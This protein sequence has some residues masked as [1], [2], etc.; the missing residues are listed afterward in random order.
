[1]KSRNPC[2]CR[3][4]WVKHP[5]GFKWTTN[6]GDGLHDIG[7]IEGADMQFEDYQ[8]Q[9]NQTAVYPPENGLAYTALGLAGE[10]GEIANKVKKVLRDDGGEL[11][12]GVRAALAGEL[13]DVLWY[14]S[15]LATEL[16][17]N[18]GGIAANNL[19]KLASRKERGVLQGSGDDR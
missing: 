4:P 7:D 2:D 6:G 1:V 9:A 18:L 10:A 17:Y 5:H 15:A 3:N 12:P 16:D 11:T 14:L 13:G 19:A 8:Q